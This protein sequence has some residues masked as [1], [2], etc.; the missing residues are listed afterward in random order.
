MQ[1]AISMIDDI[2]N[3]IEFSGMNLD[4]R[5]KGKDGDLI[6]KN[7]R[8][9]S[10]FLD[11]DYSMISQF[12]N[13]KLTDISKRYQCN[14]L[15]CA[16]RSSHVWG[17]SHNKSDNDVKAVIYYHQRDYY[18][19]IKQI[20][21]SFKCIY[22]PRDKSGNNQKKKPLQQNQKEKPLQQDQEE[23]PDVELN[24]IELTKISQMIIKNDPNI[25]EIFISP[26]P[27]FIRDK[28]VIDRF[29]SIIFATY[30]WYKLATHYIAWS[31]GNHKQLTNTSKKRIAKKPLKMLRKFICCFLR[32]YM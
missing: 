9:Q 13:T 14:V 6:L 8:I 15:Y 17:S 22:G 16:E 30:N 32:K 10:R 18:S 21:R 31:N 25:F 27:Y 3:D 7:I 20:S 5:D 4:D 19:P 11:Y 28:Q 24:C 2:I 12:V 29:R 23:E 26:I 1:Q